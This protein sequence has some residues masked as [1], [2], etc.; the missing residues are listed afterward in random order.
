[1][2]RFSTYENFL[3]EKADDAGYW[4]VVMVTR[5]QS[6][7]HQNSLWYK[8][9]KNVTLPLYAR[10][11]N[12]YLRKEF[13]T[14]E[15]EGL[16]EWE[17]IMDQWWNDSNSNNSDFDLFDIYSMNFVDENATKN[18]VPMR[19]AQREAIYDLFTEENFRKMGLEKETVWEEI[20]NSR[21]KHFG[22]KFGF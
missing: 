11:Q 15:Q 6:D 16:K 4:H 2:S 8:I 19:A 22:K 10:S 5:S 12:V 17:R 14:T 13:Q 20:R 3:R 1:M 9:A 21:G 7:P 18:A